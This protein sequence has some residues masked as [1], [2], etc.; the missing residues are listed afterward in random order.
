MDRSSGPIIKSL[1]MV[2]KSI[3]ALTRELYLLRT[4]N[5]EK[6]VG[7]DPPSPDRA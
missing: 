3:D 6:N 7:T 2:C 5:T 1:M 4:G